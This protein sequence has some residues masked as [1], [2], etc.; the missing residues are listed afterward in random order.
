MLVAGQDG[1]NALKQFC[2]Y[3]R[4][5]AKNVVRSCTLAADFYPI[6]FLFSPIKLSDCFTYYRST[7]K[8]S[9]KTFANLI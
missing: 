9:D 6:Y 7:I 5:L 2:M 1:D 8:Y 3:M 4:L